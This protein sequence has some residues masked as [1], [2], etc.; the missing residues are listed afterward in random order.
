MIKSYV[1][2]EHFL[3][4]LKEARNFMSQP[5]S[6]AITTF[7]EHRFN[8]K[9]SDEKIDIIDYAKVIGNR[10]AGREFNVAESSI[11]EWRKNEDRLR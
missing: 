11:R 7:L 5:F 1:K 4:S 8:T 10:A 6:V 3:Y 2:V 9:I